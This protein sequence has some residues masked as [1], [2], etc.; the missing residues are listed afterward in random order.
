MIATVVANVLEASSRRGTRRGW[1][2]RNRSLAVLLVSGG[3]LWASEA[4]KCYYNLAFWLKMG[5]CFGRLPILDED[6][7][8][9][10][11][12]AVDG[13]GLMGRGLGFY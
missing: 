4:V 11:G 8:P 13:G 9:G 2:R 6:G 7:R 10:F 12:Y 3:L 1:S 5:V